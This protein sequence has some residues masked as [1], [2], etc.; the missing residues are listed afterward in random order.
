MNETL[1]M[2]QLRLNPERLIRFAQDQGVN[3]TWDEDLGYCVHA[4]LAAL[5]GSLAPKPFRL[6]D[7]GTAWHKDRP[8]QW[9]G[10]SAHDGATLREQAET[11]ASPLALAVCDPVELTCAK[12]MPTT[13][14]TGR[15]LGFEVLACPVSR[16]ETERDVFLR[17]VETAIEPEVP[18]TRAEV[19]S[20]WLARQWGDAVT[21]ESTRL[22]GFR[23][24][25]MMRRMQ[26]DLDS[27]G[28]P[29]RRLVYPQ[30]LL[31]GEL[32]ICDGA[33]FATSLARGMGRHRAF[34][35]GMVLLRPLR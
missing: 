18:P 34:G 6:L 12:P 32:T 35:Y 10:Y 21:L 5:F 3:Q 11:F 8:L 1:C 19:Y 14:V 22:E 15:R 16:R 28:R 2:V 26:P 29:L 33:T 13:W 17:A 9:F 24:V 25:R 23:L 30:A 20:A 7:P 27:A 4:W 31:H